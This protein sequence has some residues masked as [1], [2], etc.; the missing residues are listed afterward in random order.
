[1]RDDPGSELRRELA[2]L[3]A[4]LHHEFAV[5]VWRFAGMLVAQAALII[6]AVSSSLDELR[7]PARLPGDRRRNRPLSSALLA[8]H[9]AAS[10]RTAP[11]MPKEASAKA[12]YPISD[13]WGVCLII[14]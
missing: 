14:C 8:P 3:R 4:A 12:D 9:R 1:L 2:D 11:S 5:F 7:K 13:R 10:I 6:V